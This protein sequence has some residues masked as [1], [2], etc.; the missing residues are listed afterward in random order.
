[1]QRSSVFARPCFSV[2]FL[3][4]IFAPSLGTE[5]KLEMK[6]IRR[7]YTCFLRTM[8]IMCSSLLHTEQVSSGPQPKRA[9]ERAISWCVTWCLFFSTNISF[10]NFC[11]FIFSFRLV[12]LTNFVCISPLLHSCF[13]PFP[14][15]FVEIEIAHY[16]SLTFGESRNVFSWILKLCQWLKYFINFLYN[17]LLA[18]AFEHWAWCVN[19]FSKIIRIPW[20]G[21]YF[22]AKVR[23]FMQSFW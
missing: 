14:W 8:F 23:T 5:E 6:W 10:S 16:W 2:V 18:F 4:T 3:I 13:F 15:H 21:Q 9:T 7:A 11:M 12:G 22:Q 20:S 19:A 1:M 17:G